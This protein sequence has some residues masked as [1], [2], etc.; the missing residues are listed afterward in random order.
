MKQQTFAKDLDDFATETEERMLFVARTAIQDTVNIAQTPVG[1]GGAMRVKTGFLRASGKS[2]LNGMPTG[3]TRGDP[4][5]TYDYDEVSIVSDLNTL[6]IG[7]T[8]FFGWTAA[9]A[10]Y[11]ELYDGFLDGALRQWQQ[12]VD[13]AVAKLKGLYK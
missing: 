11:R 10:E 7:S 13:A 9:Y 12:S 6:N 2:S 5:G 1:K 4:E 3:P 8:F